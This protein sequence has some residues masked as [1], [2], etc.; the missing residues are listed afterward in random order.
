LPIIGKLLGHF[1][2]TTTHRYAHLD[3]GQMCRAAEKIGAT[4]A[5]ATDGN[6]GCQFVPLMKSGGRSAIR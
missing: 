5:A 4:I 6:K 3:A 2:A 1:Q